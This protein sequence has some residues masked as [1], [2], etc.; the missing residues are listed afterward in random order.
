VAGK[1]QF[2]QGWKGHSSKG[3]NGKGVQQIL[4]GV[5]VHPMLSS[6]EN[7]EEKLRKGFRAMGG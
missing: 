5:E 1:R 3:C 2:H 6:D 7:Q 4:V